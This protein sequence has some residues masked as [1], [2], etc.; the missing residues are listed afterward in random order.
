MLGSEKGKKKKV[1]KEK[2]E[3]M[4]DGNGL[5]GREVYVLG[6]SCLGNCRCRPRLD[7]QIPL[8]ADSPTDMNGIGY[9]FFIFAW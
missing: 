6:I 9:L 7:E 2:L 1:G 5:W 8:R 3:K 4:E